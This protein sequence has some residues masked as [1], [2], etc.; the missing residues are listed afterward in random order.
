MNT[1]DKA[2]YLADP[3][4]ASS[5]PYWKSKR[6]IPPVGMLIL[7]QASF[8]SAAFPEY[9]DEP[10]FRLQHDLQ[11]LA[12]PVLP[13]GYTLC[14]ASFGELAAHINA[15]YGGDCVR[16][17]ELRAYTARSVYCPD[18]WLAV[19][20]NATGALAATAIAELDRE[21]GE[22]A[23]EWIQV[24]APCR[25]RGLGSYLVRELLWRLQGVARFV[26]V[27]GRCHNP[28]DPESLY[29]RCGFTGDDVWHILRKTDDRS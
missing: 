6:V 21:I 3:C 23:L 8:D 24:S 16:E 2:H 10:Y 25:R 17:E 22:G 12:A 20:E 14:R 9:T 29:R 11:G 15:C 27:S 5:L 4:K 26:T 13:Q 19:R 7:H 28:C 1:I 18:L